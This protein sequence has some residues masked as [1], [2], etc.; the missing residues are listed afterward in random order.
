M[1]EKFT[2]GYYVQEHFWLKESESQKYVGGWRNILGKYNL[3]LHPSKG[4]WRQM[5]G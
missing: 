2:E 4:A 1:V 3:S 5:Q